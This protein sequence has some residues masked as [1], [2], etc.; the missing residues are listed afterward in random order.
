MKE[1]EDI[2]K[3][4]NTIKGLGVEVDESMVVQKVLRSLPM[5]FYHKI[6]ALE[7]REGLGTLSM[8]E[9]HGIFTAYEMRTKLENPVTK[10]S[11]FK[12]SNDPDGYWWPPTYSNWLLVSVFVQHVFLYCFIIVSS[13]LL[14]LSK[15]SH[16]LQVDTGGLSPNPT[17][18]FCMFSCQHILLYFQGCF[19]ALNIF[20]WLAIVRL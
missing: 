6:L 11:P 8:E 15:A 17:G 12:E 4:V 9:L 5:R 20:F 3:I 1:D 10:E 14:G 16:I 2:A 7:E 13:T 19:G 18:L